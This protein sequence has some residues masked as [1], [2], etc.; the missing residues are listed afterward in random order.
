MAELRELQF[1]SVVATTELNYELEEFY[2]Q[3]VVFVFE[4]GI[5]PIA[6]TIDYLFANTNHTTHFQYHNI[7]KDING[8]IATNGLDLGRVDKNYKFLDTIKYLQFKYG[9]KHEYYKNRNGKWIDMSAVRPNF[10]VTR[11]SNNIFSSIIGSTLIRDDILETSIYTVVCDNTGFNSNTH[12]WNIFKVLDKNVIPQVD[13]YIVKD[14]DSRSGTVYRVGRGDGGYKQDKVK[15]FVLQDRSQIYNDNIHDPNDY[16]YFKYEYADA[17]TGTK[18]SGNYSSNDFHKYEDLILTFTK[19]DGVTPYTDLKDLLITCNGVFVDYSKHPTR[20]DCIY[21]KN[22]VKYGIS[23]ETGLKEGFNPDG[24]ITKIE[25]P[26]GTNIL[27]FDAAYQNIG[28]SQLF[29]IKIHKWED[30][31]VSRF[32]TPLSVGGINKNMPTEPDRS[33]WLTNRLTFSENIDKNKTILFR[34]TEIVP[35]SDWEV[36]KLQKNIIN[37]TTISAEFDIIYS[38]IYK[39][40]QDHLVQIMEH[41]HIQ[42]PKLED[43]MDD[44]YTSIEDVEDSMRRYTE[45]MKEFVEGGGEYKVHFAKSALSIVANQF[46]DFQYAIVTFDSIDNINYEISVIEN[47]K[48]IEFDRPY[49]DKVRIKNW[50]PDDILILNGLNHR[51]INEYEDVFTIAPTWYLKEIKGVF[52]GSEGYKLEVI[53]RNKAN[54]RYIKLNKNEIVAKPIGGVVYYTYDPK[55]DVYHK[56]GEIDEFDVNYQ[57]LSSLEIEQGMEPHVI[58]FM[59]DSLGEMVKVPPTITE[60]VSGTEYYICLYDKDYFVLLD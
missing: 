5:K 42:S 51:L 44:D 34:G 45:A 33:F 1:E 17:T 54:N 35:K 18:G 22:V 7:E 9:L 2:P 8:D 12:G 6:C 29:N 14:S 16:G 38:E 4:N 13:T 19:S 47:S 37:L 48:D 36:D 21:L 25:R 30:V 20:N 28:I 60:F 11:E 23:Q 53:R 26:N 55:K 43:Y 10:A 57:R 27:D 15:K 46:K 50:S 39:V 31:K 59:K 56:L 52:N 24:F 49:V 3:T 32:K 40:L 41:N 58:Y